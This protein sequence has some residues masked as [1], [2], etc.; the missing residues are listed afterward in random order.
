[1]TGTTMTLANGRVRA[2]QGHGHNDSTRYLHDG[3]T[4]MDRMNRILQVCDRIRLASV[5][6]K[7]APLCGMDA[8]MLEQLV[9]QRLWDLWKDEWDTTDYPYG[10]ED[11]ESAW[12]VPKFAARTAKNVR[13]EAARTSRRCGVT[14]APKDPVDNAMKTLKAARKAVKDQRETVGRIRRSLAQTTDTGEYERL[15]AKLHEAQTTLATLEQAMCEAQ[16]RK[17]NAEAKGRFRVDHVE[18]SDLDAYAFNPVTNAPAWRMLGTRTSDEADELVIRNRITQQIDPLGDPAQVWDMATGAAD[19]I[20]KQLELRAGSYGRASLLFDADRGT[21][22]HTLRNR[23][24]DCVYR[25]CVGQSETAAADLVDLI[26]GLRATG[27]KRPVRRAASKRTRRPASR[28][29]NS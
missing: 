7:W 25:M 19:M 4:V 3:I 14:L 20:L 23:L 6:R 8:P 10:G 11:D 9:Q 13:L 26:D 16:D 12:T 5:C 28:K 24:R 22:D 2:K 15:V 1:M 21:I 17:D 29:A 18:L 27:P